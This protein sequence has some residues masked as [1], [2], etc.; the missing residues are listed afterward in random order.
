M[1]GR[2]FKLVELEILALHSWLPL[3]NILV[4]SQF[5]FPLIAVN[6]LL[7]LLCAKRV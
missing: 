3:L 4:T 1:N 6:A 7:G 5:G 2:V